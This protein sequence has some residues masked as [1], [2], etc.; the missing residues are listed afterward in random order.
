MGV[1]RGIQAKQGKDFFDEKKPWS[2]VKHRIILNYYDAY[3]KIRS[4]QS[5]LFFVDGFAGAG[6]YGEKD[7]GE[8]GPPLE[9]AQKAQ[10]LLAKGATPRLAC[11]NVEADP[12]YFS[13]LS[14]LL[15]GYSTE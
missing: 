6:Y 13:R 10:H 9:L 3:V 15:A 12:A 1:D 2:R 5:H 14:T 4:N 11:I 8:P 7:H